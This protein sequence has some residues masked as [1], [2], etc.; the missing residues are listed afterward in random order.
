LKKTKKLLNMGAAVLQSVRLNNQKFFASVFQKRSSFFLAAVIP[1]ALVVIVA[2]SANGYPAPM[3][4]PLVG[5]IAMGRGGAG[6]ANSNGLYR[7]IPGS[8]LDDI[9]AK[10]NAF[11]GVVINVPWSQIEPLPD[12]ALNTSPIDRALEDMR[13]YNADPQTT[14]KLRA[15][16]RVWAGENSPAWAKSLEGPPITVHTGNPRNH[17]AYTLGRFW[18]SSYRQAWRGLQAKLAARY[19]AN[20]LIAQVSNT[21]CTSDDDEPNAIPRFQSVAEGISSIRSLK[22]AG[23]SD[24][25]FENCMLDSVHDY[26]AWTTTS[27][28]LTLGPMFRTDGIGDFQQPPHD[29][30]FTIRLISA[31]RAALGERAVLANHNLNF[32]LNRHLLPVYEAI[33]DAG[34]QIEFQTRSPKG[35]DWPNA[36]KQAVCLGAHSLELWNATGAGGF[37]DFPTSTLIDWSN[38]LKSTTSN[39]LCPSR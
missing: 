8:N 18:S 27:V 10:R 14:V 39:A 1:F 29:S 25:A 13:R 32:P 33:R 4:P 28:N 35:L 3:K 15:I 26:D 17:R 2:P 16:L 34:G 19:D 24:A 11:D 9:I 36:V 20:A 22:D 23:Y 31:F 6:P 38:E 37:V 5:L 21:S 30:G 7:N 12:G